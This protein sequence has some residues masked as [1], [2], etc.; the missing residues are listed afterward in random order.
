MF[1]FLPIGGVGYI[2]GNISYLELDSI[3]ILIDTGILFPREDSLGINYLYPNTDL[4]KGPQFKK[5]DYLFLTHAHE[6][7]IGGIKHLLQDFPNLPIVATDYT[8]SFFNKKFPKIKANFISIEDFCK[9]KVGDFDFFKIR[10]SIPGVF[11]FFYKSKIIDSGLLFC[12]DFRYIKDDKGDGYLCSKL[13]SKYSKS[14]NDISLFV[15]STNIASSNDSG[16]F[17]KDIKENLSADIIEKEDSDIYMT[18]FP[19]NIKRFS[20]IVEIANEKNLPV[21]LVGR[22]VEFSYSLGLETGRIPPIKNRKYTKG[23]S[24]V[25]LSGSQGD[26]RGAFRRV[27]TGNDKNFK[28]S[29]NDRLLFS[30]KTIPGNEKSVGEIFNL[31]SKLGV[32][33]NKGNSPLI[34]SSG[35]AYKDEISD[36]IKTLKPRLVIPIHLESSFFQEFYQKIQEKDGAEIIRL[37]NYTSL[38]ITEGSQ[39]KKTIQESADLKIYLD[40]GACTDKTIINS[41]R[42]LGIHGAIFISLT[43]DDSRKVKINHYG[44]PLF[45]ENLLKNEVLK[46]FLEEWKNNDAE[47]VIRVRARHFLSKEIGYKPLVFVHIL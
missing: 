13:L 22:S 10:H 6:D 11:G 9:L 12:T 5:I 39:Y 3:T 37:E 4:L 34:H 27:F 7:H 2:G 1:K 46:I 17:E 21:V 16:A 30:S 44:I 8:K 28:P 36:I 47:E 19:S 20:T 35:H 33:I 24:V 15:D 43:K 45:S 14:T 38:E 40:G 32:F 42:R 23:K 18:F 31:A 26:L 29:Q 41:R 25:L